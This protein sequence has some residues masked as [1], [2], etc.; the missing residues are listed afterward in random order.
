MDSFKSPVSR[1][2]RLFKRSRDAWKA[3]AL[4]KQQ[5]LRAAQVRIRDLEKS[6]AYW[7]ERALAGE[8]KED[9]APSEVAS[10]EEAP[11]EE[12]AQ[13]LA[14]STPARHGYALM[15]IQLTL[16]LYLH[17]GIGLRGVGR[18][19][20]WFA[21]W[22]GLSAGPAPN[23][24]RNWLYRCG[25]AL[26]QRPPA[27]RADWIYVIDATL[28]LGETKCLVILGI[29][30]S[31]LAQSGYSPPHQAMTVLAVQVTTHSS[32][33]WIAAVL[34]E[35]A[36]R[37]GAPM[38]IVADHG[39]DLRKGIA[40]FQEQH[41]PHC[42]ETYDISHR[43]A[44]L[45]KGELSR[46]AR[47]KTFLAQCAKTLSTWQ[48]TD[49][50]FLLPPRQRTKARYMHFDAHVQWA[51][52]LL[53]YYER[54]DFSAI[55]RPCVLSYAAWEYLRRGFGT[56]RV[57]PL[58]PLIGWR[59]AEKE[60][61]AQAL[62]AHSDIPLEEL[63][64]GFWT[65]ADHARARFLAGFA[66]LLEYRQDLPVYAAMMAS[67]KRI[68]TALKTQ[69]LGAGALPSLQAERAALPQLTPRAAAF[70]ENLI[71]QAEQEIAKVPPGQTWL[72]SSDIIESVFGRYKT[73]TE[74]GPL[75]EVG[76]LVLAIPALLTEWT[77][78]LIREALAQ[79]RTLDVERWAKTHLG[80]S[81]L[82]KRRRALVAPT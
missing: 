15:V 73:F 61:F 35:T 75:K 14:L 38:Q 24:V 2:A 78:A 43:I 72:A 17:T 36:A 20:Q 27:R 70:T 22:W 19:L 39:S 76:K 52:R 16:Q 81:L 65:L 23:S 34:A 32:G 31:I 30:L 54:G 33:T 48:Q 13:R 11:P 79:V 59:F 64:E 40:L 4:E 1:L 47:W 10:D 77:P 3:K 55:A 45:L 21:P 28:S 6:R 12:P 18:V 58:R 26:L 8:R 9:A 5:R 53:A 51:E 68:Q 67:A 62:Q 56:A 63:D 71:G 60:A 66:W 74:R 25:L 49:L 80:D 44:T 82:A 41:A 50:A 37:T 29:P 46:D 42:V 7:K 57:Q 69:G